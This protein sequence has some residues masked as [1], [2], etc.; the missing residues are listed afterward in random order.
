MRDYEGP[1]E[2]FQFKL[3]QE[4]ITREECDMR[5]WVGCT[6]RE[7]QGIVDDAIAKKRERENACNQDC[8]GRAD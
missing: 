4:G 2:F 7:L 6:Y 1:I 3:A 5:N 8:E